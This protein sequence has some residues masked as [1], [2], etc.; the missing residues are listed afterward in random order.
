MSSL[1]AFSQKTFELFDA[2]RP[3]LTDA[4][5]DILRRAYELAYRYADA[6]DGWLLLTGSYGSGKTHLAVAIANRRVS[7]YG[8]KVMMVTAPDLLDHLRSTYGPSSEIAY[9]ALFDRVRNTPLLV[10]DDLG[11]ESPTPWAREKLYQLLNHRHSAQLPTVITTN[12]DVEVMDGRIRSRL[13]D[14][15]LTR[16]VQMDIPDHRSPGAAQIELNLTNLD[17]YQSMRFETFEDRR[18]ESLTDEEKQ[19][20]ENLIGIARAYAEHP[21]GWMVFI[22]Q[23]GIGKTHLAAAIAHERKAHGDKLAFVVCSEL[24]DYLRAAFTPASPISFDKRLHEIKQA[25]FLV[26]DNLQI[27]AHTTSWTREK[28]YDILT[29]RFDCNLPTVIT[30]YQGKMDARLAS[31]IENKSRCT[32]PVWSVPPYR[33]GTH[34]RAAKP[35]RSPTSS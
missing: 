21:A 6:P 25:S 17:R 4:Q 19:Q 11:A 22:G 18:A 15:G 33:G 13:T 23:P 20:F 1:E 27:D 26:L 3:G 5:N 30:T 35:R 12:S 24:T 2:T 32:V 7:V 14:Q 28:L 31:R 16:T 29:Y 10:L 34:R 8:E 9:D